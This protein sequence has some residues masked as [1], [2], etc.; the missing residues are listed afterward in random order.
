MVSSLA[1]GLHVE[2]THNIL[3]VSHG[4]WIATLLSALRAN[5]V[6]TCREGVEIGHCL[7]TG[8]SIIEYAEIPTR[9]DPVF[10][11]TL[12]QYSDVRHVLYRNLHSLEINA[13]VLEDK[14]KKV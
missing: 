6:L 4:A 2:Q 9:K 1:T 13:D 12:V 14:G 10:M 11:G 8:V 5:R 3:I 7:N